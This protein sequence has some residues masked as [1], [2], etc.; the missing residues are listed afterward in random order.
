MCSRVGGLNGAN[1]YTVTFAKDQAPPV[2]GFWSFTLYNQHHFFE[3]NEIKRYSVGTKIKAL[4]NDP[5]GALTISVQADV[6]ADPVQRANWLPAPKGGD[7]SLYLR[8]YWPT[9]EVTGGSWTPPAVH[10][11]G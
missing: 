5:D 3:P 1:R 9:V 7:F 4:K 6:P 2:R 10:K 11:V 8:T